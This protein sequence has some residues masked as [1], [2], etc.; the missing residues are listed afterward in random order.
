MC[1][2]RGF[3]YFAGASKA[4]NAQSA[5]ERNRLDQANKNHIYYINM[6]V[7]SII[8]KLVFLY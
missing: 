6:D 1:V 5:N 8:F 7:F 2:L 4:D 3:L